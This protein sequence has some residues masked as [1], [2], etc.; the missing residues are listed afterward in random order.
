M[1]NARIKRLLVSILSAMAL[2]TLGSA[3]DRAADLPSNPEIQA[4]LNAAYEKY[5]TLQEG[6]NADYIPAL[7]AVD[8]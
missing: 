8:P 5:R 2:P 6:K 7:S 4:A 3:A 1:T